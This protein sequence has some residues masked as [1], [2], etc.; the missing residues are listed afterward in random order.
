MTTT[1][2]NRT[3]GDLREDQYLIIPVAADKRLKKFGS[4]GVKLTKSK[5]I[6]IIDDV[7]KKYGEYIL[8]NPTVGPKILKAI[9]KYSVKQIDEERIKQS[10]KYINW[11]FEVVFFFVWRSLTEGQGMPVLMGGN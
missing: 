5:M 10:Q 7:E 6:E 8:S 11:N 1:Q 9:K 2:T 4:Y 3:L